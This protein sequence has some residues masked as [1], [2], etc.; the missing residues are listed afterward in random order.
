METKLFKD[1]KISIRLANKSDI[2]NAKKFLVFIN[3]FVEE[4]AMLLMNKKT[5]LKGEVAFLEGMVRGLKNKTKIYLVAESEG[6]IVGA[7]DIELERWRRNHIGKLGIAI[8]NGY[9]GIGLGTY[10]ISQAIKLAKTNL[11]PKPKL[12]Q[13]E[14]YENNNPAISLYKKMGFKMVAKVPKQVQY[15]GKLISDIIM[16]KEI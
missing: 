5:N 16:I 14:A 13:L 1:K 15:N 8:I 6:K 3:S 11:K 4:N 7:T 12:I 2:K 9:R 10:L